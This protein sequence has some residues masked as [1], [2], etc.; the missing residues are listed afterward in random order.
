MGL[1]SSRGKTSETEVDAFEQV[2]SQV[3]DVIATAGVVLDENNNVL[4]ASPGAVQFG[5]VQNR[6]LIH[7]SLVKLCDRAR[8]QTGAVVEEMLLET[9]LQREP[10]WVQARAARFGEK[11]MMLLVDDRT[12]AKKL[13]DT[14][15]DFVANVSHELKTPI[16]AIGLLAEAI[17]GAGDDPKMIEKFSNSLIRESQRLANLVQELMQLSRVQSAAGLENAREVDLAAVVADAIER[18]QVLAEKRNIRVQGATSDSLK[19]LGDYEMLATAVRNLIENAIVYSEPGTQ[20]GVGLKEVDGVAE[21]SVSD[22]GIGIPESEQERIFERFY[23]VDPSRSR[24]TGGT[25]LGLAIVKHIAANHG[26]QIKLFSKQGVGS[27]FTL[28]LPI[29]IQEG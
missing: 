7:S 9:G 23:R 25:G 4:R 1:W 21:I 8:N 16:G 6:R 20:V 19:I 3:V 2:A 12:E 18:N 14:R 15:R 26:G 28:R 22:S 11:Y 27:T 13:E 17:Q 5:L 10:V 29:T 24:E